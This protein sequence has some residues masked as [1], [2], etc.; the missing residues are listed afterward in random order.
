MLGALASQ[1]ARALVSV[2]EHLRDGAGE[3][4]ALVGPS[5]AGKSTLLRLMAGLVL[6]SR[7]EVRIVETGDRAAPLRHGGLYARMWHSQQ[8]EAPV[9]P[10]APAAPPTAATVPD[11]A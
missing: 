6:P 2:D 1:V 11:L 10:V 5:G 7:A 3:Y 8:A 9:A 4:V